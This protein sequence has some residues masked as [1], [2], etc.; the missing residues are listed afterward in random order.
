MG[1][2]LPEEK[3][4]RCL[5]CKQTDTRPGTATLTLKHGAS[6]FVV[7]DVPAQVCPNCGEEYVDADVTARLQRSAEAMAH[8][9][10]SLD[11]RSFADAA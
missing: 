3:A 1:K 4:V 11:V 10:K 7:N 5:I 8:S 9:G 6:T 2:R